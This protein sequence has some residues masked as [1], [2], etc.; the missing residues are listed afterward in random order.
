M[1]KIAQIWIYYDSI[2]GLV[3]NI[4]NQKNV[5]FVSK[6]KIMLQNIFIVLLLS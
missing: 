2:M 3:R 6:V 4:K 5:D 1:Q